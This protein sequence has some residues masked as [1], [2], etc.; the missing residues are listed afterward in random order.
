VKR[1]F[2]GLALP[3]LIVMTAAWACNMS[4]AN[5]SELKVGK[6]KDVTQA[7]STFKAG[8][9]IYANAVVSNNPGKVTVKMHIVVDDAPGMTKGTMVPNSDVSMEVDGDGTVR[10]NFE[11]SPATKGGKFTVVAD[12]L[13]EEGEKKDGKTASFTVEPGSGNG[14]DADKS[15]DVGDDK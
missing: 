15:T 9:T 13:N 1:S 6:D 11:T 4:T 7:A 14:A 2:L 8:D 3:V 10:Y 12:M 5:L